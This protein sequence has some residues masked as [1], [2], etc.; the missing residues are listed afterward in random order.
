[1][2]LSGID[3]PPSCLGYSS[4]PPARELPKYLSQPN[5]MTDLMGHP[6]NVLKMYT[7]SKHS[8]RIYFYWLSILLRFSISGT[9]T[10]LLSLKI[11]IFTSSFQSQHE[12][13]G[14]GE[15][16]VGV[17]GVRAMLRAVMGGPRRRGVPRISSFRTAN[18]CLRPRCG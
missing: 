14:A 3:F 2:G 7:L 9:G 17:T 8:M 18:E 10:H 13:G 5:H 1:M 16:G 12:C 6:V 11:F 15:W 4:C